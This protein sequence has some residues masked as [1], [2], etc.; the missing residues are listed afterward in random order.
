M[1]SQT[2]TPKHVEI[3]NF[4]IITKFDTTLERSGRGDHTF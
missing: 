3:I 4:Q 2:S 1:P